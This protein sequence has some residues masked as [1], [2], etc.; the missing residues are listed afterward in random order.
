MLMAASLAGVAMS[1][2]S[3]HEI[4]SFDACAGRWNAICKDRSLW[5]AGDYP[6]IEAQVRPDHESKRAQL[7]RRAPHGRWTL[8]AGVAVR[9]DG[10]MTW[11]WETTSDDIRRRPWRFQY[12]LFGHDT[13]SDIVRVKVV[14]PPD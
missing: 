5:L 2:A 9:D 12:G 4:R 7:W 11:Q 8:I 3:A 10:R 13:T 6:R 1:S 14:A